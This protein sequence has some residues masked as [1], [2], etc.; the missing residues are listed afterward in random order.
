[1]AVD[2]AKQ[3]KGTLNILLKNAILPGEGIEVFKR[4]LNNPI[5]QVVVSTVDLMARSKRSAQPDRLNI[6]EIAPS[7]S[8]HKRP[9]LNT[10]YV[11]PQNKIELEIVDIWQNLL[12]IEQVGINDNFFDLGATSLDI[13]QVSRKLKEKTG[14]DIPVVTLYNYS[15][16]GELAQYLSQDKVDNSQSNEKKSQLEA[17]SKGKYILRQRGKRMKEGENV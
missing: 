2:T 9:E 15:S 7:D 13:L 16:V 11:A 17:I 4:I 12:G 10:S 8:F 3:Y 5:T 6:Q 14:K 1:M